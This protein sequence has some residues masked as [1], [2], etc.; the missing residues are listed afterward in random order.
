MKRFVMSG[1]MA[2]LMAPALAL[3]FSATYDQRITGD[4]REIESSVAMKDGQFRVDMTLDGQ[5]MIMLKNAEG[6]FN[7]MVEHGMAMKLP[8]LDKF[9]GP[10]EGIDRADYKDFLRERNA[11]KV[12]S[13]V[14]NGYP[15]DVYEYVDPESS[16]P[17]QVWVWTQR[18]FPV[19]IEMAGTDGTTVVEIRNI[20]LDT[21]IDASIFDLPPGVRVMDMGG[22]NP[23]QMMQ[24][25]KGAQRDQ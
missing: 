9:Q 4:G 23:M 17:V 21:S 24:Q 3:A 11:N 20:K 2:W 16:K 8:Q 13:E 25:M 10:P 19:K 7:V 12:G 5:R 15:T 18:A 22:F 6:L 1:L 14:V